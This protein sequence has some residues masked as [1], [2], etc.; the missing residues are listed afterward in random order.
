M[1][2]PPLLFP[3]KCYLRTKSGRPDIELND[4]QQYL[5][6]W[7]FVEC[8]SLCTNVQSDIMQNVVLL[9]VIMRSFML[10]RVIAENRHSEC[11]F[12]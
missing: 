9:S 8:Y 3:A 5:F 10:L 7:Y 2:L 4:T 1:I 11:H 6:I 12:A